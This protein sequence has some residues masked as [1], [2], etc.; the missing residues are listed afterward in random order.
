MDPMGP[1]GRSVA[2]RAGRAT[3]D[4]YEELMEK[5]DSLFDT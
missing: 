4:D 3:N 1:L 5:V 2:A